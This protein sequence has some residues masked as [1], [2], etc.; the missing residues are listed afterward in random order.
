ML[1]DG[2]EGGVQPG[3]LGVVSG[4]HAN[5]V[6]SRYRHE[7]RTGCCLHARAPESTSMDP[8]HDSGV[9]QSKPKSTRTL[10]PA[11]DVKTH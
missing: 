2:D 11:I 3:V 6:S 10:N 5:F 8:S 1:R 9:S 4:R 7:S